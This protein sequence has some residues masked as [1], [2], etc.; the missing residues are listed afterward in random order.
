[1]LLL[2]VLFLIAQG[3]IYSFIS[4]RILIKKKYW[5][6]S[7]SIAFVFSVCSY[8]LFNIRIFLL[9]A[10]DSWYSSGAKKKKKKELIGSCE[11]GA[12]QIW[13]S[14]QGDRIGSDHKPVTSASFLFVLLLW[15]IKKKKLH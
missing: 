5:F 10:S 8:H 3:C 6:S 9:T 13:A 1:M 4:L 7:P 11:D 15:T 14:P 2:I 12:Y